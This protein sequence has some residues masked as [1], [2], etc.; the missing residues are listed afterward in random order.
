MT[1]RVRTLIVDDEP[2]ARDGLRLMLGAVPDVDVVG[3]AGEGTA[4]VEAI[5]TLRPDVVLRRRC[6]RL[7]ASIRLKAEG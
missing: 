7:A 3:E 2:L 5:R 6:S 4:A 1:P